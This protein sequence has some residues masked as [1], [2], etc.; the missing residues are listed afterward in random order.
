MTPADAVPRTLP[1]GLRRHVFVP[2]GDRVDRRQLAALL[3]LLLGQALR[4]GTDAATGTKGHPLRQIVLSMSLVGLLVASGVAR[5]ESADAFLARIFFGA[6]VLTALA[7]L[8]DPPEMRER[9]ADILG[10]KPL[11]APTQLVAHA[12]LL[13]VLALLISVPFALPG[14][15]AAAW[16]FGLPAWRVP[17]DLLA[18]AAGGFA[19]ALVWVQVILAAAVRLGVERVRQA[20]QSLL[21]LVV[22][23]VTLLAAARLTTGLDLLPA[24]RLRPLLA[25]LPSTWFACFWSGAGFA[26]RTGALLL[27]A[28]SLLLFARRDLR[29]YG[30]ALSAPARQPA[31]A[32]APWAARA[33]GALSEAPL[34]GRWLL[35][36]AAAGVAAAL[37]TLSGREDVARMKA[38]STGLVALAFFAWGLWS[39]DA[40]AP[41]WV[42]CY[43]ALSSTLDGLDAMRQS[44]HADAAWLFR[45]APADPAS[46]VSGF[47]WAVALR[48]GALP[49]LLVATLIP[50]RQPLLLGA[51]LLGALF[52]L[53][54]LLIAVGLVLYPALPLSR[55]PRAGQGVATQ[56]LG[57]VASTFAV[58]VYGA[59]WLFAE[60]TGPV[61]PLV[62]LLATGSCLALTFAA[63]AWAAERVRAAQF[64]A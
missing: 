3:R 36:A 48:Y 10:S 50:L 16:R 58:L 12:L 44:A 9:N 39:R 37:V 20:A 57:W 64:E 17:A 24:A 40:V 42:L 46:Y 26:Q 54:R 53:A 30:E 1:A 34:I 5:A 4:R 59:L 6:F 18:L 41:F 35:P 31:R 21:M 23:G 45:M 38:R 22:V 63:R 62:V 2:A 47:Q 28:A 29:R 32:A 49:L 11:S 27:V 15:L 52:A 25:S 43:F 61:G 55:A 8:P 13:F 60:W 56:L 33:L 7:I 19:L 14:I 51:L